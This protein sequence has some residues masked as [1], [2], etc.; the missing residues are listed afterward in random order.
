[1]PEVQ[2]NPTRRPR[3]V[4]TTTPRPAPT[5]TEYVE[6][7]LPI[8]GAP[9]IGRTGLALETALGLDDVPINPFTGLQQGRGVRRRTVKRRRKRGK[10]VQGAVFSKFVTIP[11]K[12]EAAEV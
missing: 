10:K 7:P 5:T 9:R 4:P 8:Y 1:M 6:A 3:P 12:E 11:V 2:L